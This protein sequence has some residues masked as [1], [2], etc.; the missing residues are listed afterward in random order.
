MPR[1]G[2]DNMMG[3]RTDTERLPWQHHSTSAP[4]S[5]KSEG[6][7]VGQNVSSDSVVSSSRTGYC[8]WSHKLLLNQSLPKNTNKHQFEIIQRCATGSALSNINPGSDISLPNMLSNAFD[9]SQL[10]CNP[11]VLAALNIMTV[12]SFSPPRQETKPDC[13]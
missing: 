7:C 3:N 4:Y 10:Q 13:S 1:E 5:I 8:I 6:S 2:F 9:Q 12:S 11:C